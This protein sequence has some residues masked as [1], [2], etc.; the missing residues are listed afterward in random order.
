MGAK[1]RSTITTVVK[2]AKKASGATTNNAA[3]QELLKAKAVAKIQQLKA[4]HLAP[5]PLVL[6]VLVC[7]GFMWMLAFRDLMATGRPIMGRMDE[8]MQ[9]SYHVLAVYKCMQQNI[10][11]NYF[12]CFT[13]IH[14]IN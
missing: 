6:T 8:A 1:R 3:Q 2:E 14:E 11:L 13:A 5:L 7:S 9:V 10:R 12:L 4:L